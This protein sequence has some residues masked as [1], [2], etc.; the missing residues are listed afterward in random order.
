L[1]NDYEGLRK[2]YLEQMNDQM[3]KEKLLIYGANGYTGRLIL[4]R[5]REY[6][7][8]AL[9][10]GR[11][12]QQVSGL[13]A[14]YQL[15]FEILKLTEEEKLLTLLREVTIVLHVAGP[16][17]HTAQP[18]IEAC[19]KTRTHYLDI[20][21]EIEIFEMAKQYSEAAK[22]A[23]I[24]L[25]PG[26]GFDVVPT[27]CLALYLKNKLP[28]ATSLKLAF[29]T[30]GGGLSHGTA[31][32]MVE[33]LGEGGAVRKDGVIIRK[34]LG[35]KGRWVDFGGRKL[36]VMTIP[37]GDV[38]TAYFTTGIQDIETY[39]GVK[40]AVF[41]LLT[42]QGLLNWLLRTNMVKAWLRAKINNRAAGPSAETR[43]KAKSL[44]WGEVKNRTGKK[45]TSVLETPDGY[46]L[47]AHSSLIIASRILSGDFK[48]GY[49]TPASAY[50]EGLVLEVPGTRRLVG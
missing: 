12:V 44:V 6:K 35:H 11:D 23:G 42:L 10:A 3:N 27:D 15:P 41:R 14:T 33:G 45:E 18:M 2:I 29:A 24:M 48:P 4:E 46:T 5:L 50:G 25:M 28:D 21:G 20:T 8:T 39:T 13:A 43:S 34:P 16:F 36:F 49:Q 19:I 40:P 1:T 26:A 22:D 30:L 31:L 7:L 9:I 38:S 17:K 47:T 37:W 32:T